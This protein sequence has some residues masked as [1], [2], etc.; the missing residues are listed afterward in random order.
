MVRIGAKPSNS[1]ERANT[2]L[3]GPLASSVE[4]MI[5]RIVQYIEVRNFFTILGIWVSKDA[6]FYAYFKNINIPH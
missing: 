5:F 4:V 2:Y 6:E 1:L 3:F